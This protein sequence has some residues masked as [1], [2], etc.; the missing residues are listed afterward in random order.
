MVEHHH[1]RQHRV[2][3]RGES[4]ERAH[5]GTGDVAQVG[6]NP[7]DVLWPTALNQGRIAGANM[8]GEKLPYVK[9]VACNVTMLT[10]L[11]VTI[12]GNVGRAPA[13]QDDS[14]KDE[15]TVAIVRGEM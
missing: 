13:G 9:G 3:G 1:R 4:G 12:I 8:A 6:S 7:L 14:A 2:L 5:I 10:G 15:D 11:K